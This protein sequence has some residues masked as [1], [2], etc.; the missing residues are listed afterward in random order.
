MVHISLSCEQGPFGL[1]TYIGRLQPI[2]RDPKDNGVK[3]KELSE[4]PF[5][6]DHQ[7]DGN[8][9]TRKPKVGT[10]K[11]LCSQSNISCD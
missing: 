11:G 8:N 5:V 1:P 7:H 6:F 9:V 2:P 10:S 3:G 4:N